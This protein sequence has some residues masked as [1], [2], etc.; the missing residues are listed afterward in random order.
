[1]ET[2]NVII[3]ARL[4]ERIEHANSTVKLVAPQNSILNTYYDT[5]SYKI[6]PS[7]WMMQNGQRSYTAL[8]FLL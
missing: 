3:D 7:Q 8:T 2:N 5:N 4:K 1:M 6:V